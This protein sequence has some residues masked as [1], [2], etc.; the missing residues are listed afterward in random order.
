VGFQD[1]SEPGRHFEHRREIV[2]AIPVLVSLS[3]IRAEEIDFERASGAE[4][5]HADR[6][7]R[8]SRHTALLKNRPL[9]IFAACVALFQVANASVMASRWDAGLVARALGRTVVRKTRSKAATACRIR[10]PTDPRTA[11]RFDQQSACVLCK[12]QRPVNVI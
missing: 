1:F 8:T 11:V 9:L 7:E 10:G 5:V 2:L 12:S 3:Q 6:P 4:H